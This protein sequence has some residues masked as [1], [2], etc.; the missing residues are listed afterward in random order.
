MTLFEIFFSLVI[1]LFS[2][3]IHEI[4]H[5]SVALAFGDMTAKDSGRLSLNPL[6]HFDFFGFILLPLLTYII[7]GFPIGSAKPVPINPSNFRN[8]KVGEVSVALAGPFTNLLIGTIFALPIRF[9]SSSSSLS[10]PFSFVSFFNFLLGIFNLIPIPPLDGSHI[11]LIFFPE[12]WIQ[13]KIFLQQ[14]GFIILI[15]LIFY[16][17]GFILN[18]VAIL[19]QYLF[20]F[21]SGM[22]FL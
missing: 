11:L 3:I 9:L 7:L 19:A 14:F 1:V 2:I 13:L 12:N 6:K 22:T 21:L 15:L 5:G 18:W 10:M 17:G 8:R 4:A 16:G 20:K